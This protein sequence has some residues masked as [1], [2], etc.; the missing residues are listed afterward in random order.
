MTSQIRILVVDDHA[1]TRR[2]IMSILREHDSSWK[3][4]EAEDG[5]QAIVIA[6]EIRPEII[7]LDYN[8]PKLNGAKT[9]TLFAKESPSS[10]IIIVTMETDPGILIDSVKAGVMGI[11]S[12]NSYDNDLLQAIDMVKNGISHI[13]E[14]VVT[15]LD[16]IPLLNS[17]RGRTPHQRRTVKL[18]KREKEIFQYL[19]KGSSINSISQYL[20]I[21]SRTVHNQKASIF[22]KCGV[23][24]TQE[25]IGFAYKNRLI[26]L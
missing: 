12:K 8:M 24:S 19:I 15:R 25:L 13:P 6:R 1:L 9:A 10:K 5:V 4:F 7:L 18:S 21:T 20:G 14:E 11:V 2:G 3:I 16:G 22:R 17:R 26:R 23:T